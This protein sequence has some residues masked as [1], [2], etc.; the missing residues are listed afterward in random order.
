MKTIP[1]LLI[2]SLLSGCAIG[3]DEENLA[4]DRRQDLVGYI[5][6]LDGHSETE[7]APYD[8]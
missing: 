3:Y 1:I 5:L 7:Y 6:G 8:K 4:N 2:L